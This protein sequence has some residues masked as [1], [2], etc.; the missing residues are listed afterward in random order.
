VARRS[1]RPYK[2]KRKHRKTDILHA[3]V[4]KKI[5]GKI[6]EILYKISETCTKINPLLTKKYME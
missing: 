5:T 4:W 1:D 2:S 3:A 6:N